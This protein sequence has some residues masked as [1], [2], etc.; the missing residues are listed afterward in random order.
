MLRRYGPIA[1]AG[2]LYV[3]GMWFLIGPW[4]TLG[5]CSGVTLLMT[6]IL[7]AI[8]EQHGQRK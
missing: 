6:S 3:G 7:Q 4:L 5:I 8:G 2:L 1:L